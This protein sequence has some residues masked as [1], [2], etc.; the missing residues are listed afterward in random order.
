MSRKSERIKREIENRN[1]A[2]RKKQRI[3]REILAHSKTLADELNLRLFLD[4]EKN[5]WGDDEI[6][7]R[8]L[9]LAGMEEL[10]QELCEPERMLFVESIVVTD[11]CFLE[12]G[13]T[14]S[15]KRTPIW[16]QRIFTYIRNLLLWPGRGKERG[17]YAPAHNKSGP[18]PITNK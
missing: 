7:R 11:I 13:T 4:R 18:R 15:R 10:W 1:A 6:L 3:K 2:H 9:S 16:V 8:I 17:A 12:K 14:K 5:I